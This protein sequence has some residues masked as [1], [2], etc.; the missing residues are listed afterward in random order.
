MGLI[1]HYDGVQ[2]GSFSRVAELGSLRE[3][4]VNINLMV[5]LKKKLE[6]P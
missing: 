3:I 2:T 4:E 5:Q 6:T 1:V